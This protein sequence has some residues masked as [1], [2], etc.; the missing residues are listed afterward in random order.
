M[1]AQDARREIR[2]LL[3]DRGLRRRVARA[4]RRGE[5]VSDPHDSPIAVGYADA[6]LEWLSYR[7][8]L[9]PFYLLVAIALL[10]RVIVTGHWYFA[11][12]VYP[13]LGFGFVRLR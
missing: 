10:L 11:Q 12:L 2:W 3:L 13:A 7:G 4:A 8:R 5:R 6:S 9:V 1:A